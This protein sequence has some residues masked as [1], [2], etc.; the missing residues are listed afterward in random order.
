MEAFHLQGD[1]LFDG[2][3]VRRQQAAELELVALALRKGGA[4][5][6]ARVAEEAGAGKW[7]FSRW[8]APVG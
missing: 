7:D 6:V 1:L 3:L 4:L 5:V 8:W 2:Q